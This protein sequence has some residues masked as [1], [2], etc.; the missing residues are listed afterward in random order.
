MSSDANTLT[1]TERTKGSAPSPTLALD[2]LF[3][4]TNDQVFQKLFVIFAI[5][6]SQKHFWQTLGLIQL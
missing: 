5:I 2:F 6:C 1:M 3:Y 4:V